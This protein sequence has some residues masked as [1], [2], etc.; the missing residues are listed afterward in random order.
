MLTWRQSKAG[1]GKFFEVWSIFT[2]TSLLF[3]IEIWNVI[4]SS[5]MAIMEKLKSAILGWQL[6]CN[7]LE[8]EVLLV[9]KMVWFFYPFVLKNETAPVCI[10]CTTIRKI[11]N[12]SKACWETIHRFL[13]S[14]L[15]YSS[16]GFNGEFVLMITY[17]SIA[18]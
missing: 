2:I 1:Q 13:V 4:T 9:R 18:D 12:Y 3:F 10:L 14:L 8:L 17:I 16:L 11:L 6:S 7:N 15:T 5:W